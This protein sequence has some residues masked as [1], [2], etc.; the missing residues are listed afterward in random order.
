[1]IEKMAE[2]VRDK[3]IEGISDIRD[4]SD[5]QGYRVVIELKRDAVADVILNQLYRFTPLQTS[6]G[7]NMVA[8]NGGKPEVLTLTDM[9]KAFVAFREE[10]ISRR[11]KFLLRKA[12]DRAHVLV[13][14]AIAVA[15]IDEVIKLIRTAPDPQTARE[16]LMER[17]WPSGDVESLI[18]LIDDPRHRI[19]EDGTY[20]LSE[21]QARAILELRLQR[22]TALGRDEIADELNTIG[23]EIMDY[24]DILSSR[25]RIQQIVKDEL[26]AVR[27]EFGTPRRTE[28]TDGGADMEDEDL[29]QREDMVVTVSHSGYIKRVPLSLYR[30]QRRGGKGRSGMSTKEED[31]VT[32]LFVANTHTPVLFFSS[33]G[34]VYKEKVW[35]LPIGNPQS[36]GKALINMLPLEQGE[37][38][39]T[40][41]PL[42]EDETSWGELDVMFATTRGTVR[43]NKL[44]DF[45]QVNRNGKIAM[46]L[47]EEGD[48]ILGVETCTDNDDVL[49]TASSGQCIRFS[50]SDVRVFQSRNSVGVRGIAMADTDR[51]ISMAVIEHVDAS[52]AERAAYLKRVVAERRL[53]AGIAA[54]EEEEIALTNEEIGEETELSDERYEFLKAH[55]QFVL[56]VTEYG[57]GKRSSSYDFRLT[58]RGG[59]GIRA[60]DVS[61]V[62]EIGQSGGDLPGR[63]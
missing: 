58:G 34:I 24:L 36:R 20:N 45:V 25:A 1:M 40:I 2:L 44:S 9:L 4:E 46:K 35:R 52:P 54:G 21:E 3:R 18:L 53:A 55:E 28:L 26:A 11:T 57:Y 37:R 42:P 49:L 62:A 41:M 47:E 59:K 33:R 22:L 17:R 19:N 61:K 39:T 31:F 60:T 30:A 32:R 50:V 7:A 51:V 56:T 43:R 23:D 63:Q 12:R 16:Q 13:G 29:I 15:N 27:D 38:I 8:L 14:L 6:F 10:V 48:E 5:R